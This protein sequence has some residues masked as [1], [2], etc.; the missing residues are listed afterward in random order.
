M[1]DEDDPQEVTGYEPMPR[2]SARSEY[3]T[4]LQS[5]RWKELRLEALAQEHGRCRDCGASAT[6]VHHICYPH[7][8][9]EETIDDLVAVCRTCHEHRHA[10]LR[11]QVRL[12]WHEKLAEHIAE[13][14]TEDFALLLHELDRTQQ[15]PE[16]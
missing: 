9:G 12:A 2:P 5:E 16:R 4:Y 13:L 8:F 14:P 11:E 7:R 3:K 6:E 10:D 15:P 1:V